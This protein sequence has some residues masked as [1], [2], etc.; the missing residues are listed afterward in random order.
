MR[1]RR[2]RSSIRVGR[3]RTP[4]AGVW[5]CVSSWSDISLVS[6]VLERVLHSRIS[7]FH[8]EGEP[9]SGVE[10]YERVLA[11]N[12]NAVQILGSQVTCVITCLIGRC[13]RSLRRR[14]TSSLGNRLANLLVG[15]VLSY[16]DPFGPTISNALPNLIRVVSN[17][18]R[19]TRRRYNFHS[20]RV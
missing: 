11:P 20:R 8:F 1:E 14:P 6:C 7:S 4:R 15:C 19:V 16:G 2:D 18:L 9:T 12:A 3:Q 13:T 10:I 17:L 5:S